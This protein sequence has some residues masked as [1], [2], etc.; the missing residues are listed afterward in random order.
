MQGVGTLE[1]FKALERKR[2][3]F[4]E[5]TRSI[6]QVEGDA[7]LQAR[8]LD[9]LTLEGGGRLREADTDLQL[10]VSGRDIH[11]MLELMFE[12]PPDIGGDFSGELSLVKHGKSSPDVHFDVE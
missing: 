5:V 3:G 4:L 9:M 10:K 12:E 2:V 6:G 1:D 8:L 7:V 11:G